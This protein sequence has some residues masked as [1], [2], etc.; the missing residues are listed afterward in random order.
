MIELPVRPFKLNPEGAED[1]AAACGEGMTVKQCVETFA[2]PSTARMR[3]RMSTVW[4]QKADWTKVSNFCSRAWE[5]KEPENP[6][7]A[8]TRG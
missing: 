2:S 7:S 4:S 1:E 3:R 8:L 5:S 6:R